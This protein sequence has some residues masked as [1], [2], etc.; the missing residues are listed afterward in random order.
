MQAERAK[1]EAA[2]AAEAEQAATISD[3]AK[4]LAMLIEGAAG[5][6]MN[7][8]QRQKFVEAKTTSEMMGALGGEQGVNGARQ[9]LHACSKRFAAVQREAEHRATERKVAGVLDGM[10]FGRGRGKAE[11]P[12]S[13]ANMDT[14]ESGANADRNALVASG[15][16]HRMGDK[17][18]AII[19]SLL[20]AHRSNKRQRSD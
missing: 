18:G 1:E 3:A 12:E 8:E 6:Q 10:D 2:R 7:D 13:G 9:L 11:A 20:A 4:M 16:T 17:S 14:D 15:Y 19:G 5:Q